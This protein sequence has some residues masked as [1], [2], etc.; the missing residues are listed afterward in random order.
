MHELAVQEIIVIFLVALVIFGPKKLPQLAEDLA[1]AL[2]EFSRGVAQI[3][4]VERMPRATLIPL[5][6]A[7]VL[8]L[9]LLL[10]TADR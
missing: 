7:A 1:R 10:L 9:A 6:L 2:E 5:S 8:L 4:P 3:R